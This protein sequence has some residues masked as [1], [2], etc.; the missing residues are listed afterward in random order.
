MDA[1]LCSSGEHKLNKWTDWNL[2][3][4]IFPG[5]LDFIKSEIQQLPYYS[6]VYDIQSKGLQ[7]LT[8]Q[9]KSTWLWHSN[10]P[11]PNMPSCNSSI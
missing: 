5:I 11:A 10:T 7:K 6:R 9:V 2:L 3:G 8:N 1:K 4:L